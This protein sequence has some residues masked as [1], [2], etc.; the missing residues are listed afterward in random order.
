MMQTGDTSTFAATSGKRIIVFLFLCCTT[1]LSWATQDHGLWFSTMKLRLLA[2]KSWNGGIADPMEWTR[3][4]NTPI[5]GLANL[6]LNVA[7]PS[8]AGDQ[9]LMANWCSSCFPSAQQVPARMFAICSSSCNALN[10]MPN[11]CRVV[12]LSGTPKELLAVQ[13]FHQGVAR[14][15]SQ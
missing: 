2:S 7:A 12:R 10:Q 8:R 9:Q 4:R 15:S 14:T 13:L 5:K 3:Q 1:E 11:K 6:L